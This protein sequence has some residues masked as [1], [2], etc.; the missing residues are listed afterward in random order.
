MM[1]LWYLL[2]VSFQREQQMLVVV[3]RYN[4]NYDLYSNDCSYTLYVPSFYSAN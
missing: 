3:W 2:I 1:L 4:N